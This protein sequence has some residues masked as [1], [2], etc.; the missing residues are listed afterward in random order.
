MFEGLIL[1]SPAFLSQNE[2]PKI[3]TCEGRDISPPIVWRGV[4]TEA[5]SLVL[6]VEDPDAP[7]PHAPKMVWDHWIVFNI[8]NEITSIPENI[9]NMVDLDPR[10]RLGKNSWDR[11]SYGGPCPPIGRH[12][13]IFKLYALNINLDL[14]E[15]AS[16]QEILRAMQGHILK[17]ATLVGTYQK[18][19]QY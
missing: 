16:K 13:Y 5:I 1:E 15:G 17:E 9:K 14:S 18:Y 19:N 6:I 2:I 10:I 11:L 12:R 4:P 8:P 3:Y 7:D